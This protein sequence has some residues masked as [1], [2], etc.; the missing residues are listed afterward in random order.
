MPLVVLCSSDFDLATT[1][2]HQLEEHLKG[3]TIV[4]ERQEDEERKRRS[5]FLGDV[6]RAL[7]ARDAQV[8]AC[9]TNKI[10]GFRYQLYCLARAQKTANCTIHCVSPHEDLDGDFEPPNANSRWDCP[11]FFFVPPSF[12]DIIL[13]EIARCLQGEQAKQP[14][15]AVV[16]DNAS[17]TSDYLS[18]VDSVCIKIVQEEQRNRKHSL[19]SLQAAHRQFLRMLKAHPIPK[20]AVDQS[21]RDFL[22]S[23]VGK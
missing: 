17:M 9:G 21:F 20:D 12:D 6:E 19:S 14:S 15:P 18:C 2:A 16:A 3:A 5:A 13:Q 11:L 23:H 1:C 10:K 7:A 4:Y 8:I 22:Q